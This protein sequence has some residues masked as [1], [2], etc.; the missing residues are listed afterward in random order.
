MSLPKRIWMTTKTLLFYT[1]CLFVLTVYCSAAFFIMPFLNE[2][3][4]QTTLSRF[5]VFVLG[6]SKWI[7]GIR[8]EVEGLDNI[9]EGPCVILSN[10]QSSWETFFLQTIFSPLSTVLKQELLSV[11]FFGWGAKLTKAIPLDRKQPT[12]AYKQLINEGKDRVASNRSVLI[13]PEGTRVPIGDKV[14]F[15]RGGASLAHLA[16][17]PIVPVAH[18][19]GLLWPSNRFLMAPG[20][21]TVRIG[22][23]IYATNLNKKEMY[24]QSTS[25]I[26][27]NRDGLITS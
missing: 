15:N 9:P 8:Y 14:K 5:N 7:C 1:G 22:Q 24:E 10:H 13:F 20:K 19:A 25:W 2:R 3:Q 12:K 17:V 6:W 21:V 23:P 18:N 27:S 26:E 4:Q 16:K 11:P